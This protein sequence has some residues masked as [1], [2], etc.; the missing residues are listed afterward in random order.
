MRRFPEVLWKGAASNVIGWKETWQDLTLGSSTMEKSVM[1]KEEQ[2]ASDLRELLA[3]RS[4][5]ERC[6]RDRGKDM[7]DAPS[8]AVAVSRRI[9]KYLRISLMED[10][11]ED[12]EEKGLKPKRPK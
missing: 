6:L 8:P 10:K 4:T 11:G 9:V 12:E 1:L 3:R 2:S 5:A 7:F